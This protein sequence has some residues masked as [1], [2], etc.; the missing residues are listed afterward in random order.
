MKIQELTGYIKTFTIEDIQILK[1]V[2]IIK[3]LQMMETGKIYFYNLVQSLHKQI[4]SRGRQTL[5]GPVVQSEGHQRV[6]SISFT[7]LTVLLIY[8]F[9]PVKYL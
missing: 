4:V 3:R 5:V 7:G 1:K 2:V 9:C 8:S 6:K